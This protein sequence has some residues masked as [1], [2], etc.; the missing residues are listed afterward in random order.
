MATSYATPA[1]LAAWTGAT[2]PTNASQL[3]RSASLVITDATFS[4]FYATLNGVPTDANVLQAFQDATCA[5]AA[6]MTTLSIDPLA[7]GVLTA[8]VE[9]RSKIGSAEIWLADGDAA[10]AAKA[11]A[12]TTIVPEAKLIL[13][14]AGIRLNSPWIVG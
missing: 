7:G 8:N 6:A 9:S 4:A 5:Q 12:L 3:L 1:Q 11:R 14:Q 2:A 10:A 13:E